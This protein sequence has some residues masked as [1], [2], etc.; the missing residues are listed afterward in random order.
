ME[1]RE[2]KL[3]GL[4]QPLLPP[5]VEN[6]TFEDEGSVI[7]EDNT[8][9]DHLRVVALLYFLAGVSG[10][11]W[12]RFSTVYYLKKGLTAPQIGVLECVMPAT[13]FVSGLYVT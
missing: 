2:R 12:G 7:P 6:E 8:R 4:E 11:T 1:E 13:R 3:A 9:W 10:S 5:G